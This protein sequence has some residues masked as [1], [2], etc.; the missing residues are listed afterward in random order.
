MNTFTFGNIAVGCQ[1]K[2]VNKASGKVSD[3]G[4]VYTKIEPFWDKPGSP[5]IPGRSCNCRYERNGKTYFGNMNNA[6]VVVFAS[7]RRFDSEQHGNN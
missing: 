1:F 7:Q 2:I 6:D 3:V 4:P 5:T